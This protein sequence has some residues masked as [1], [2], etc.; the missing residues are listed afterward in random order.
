MVYRLIGFKDKKHPHWELIKLNVSLVSSVEVQND[1]TLVLH[2]CFVWKQL[3]VTTF[4]ST[5]NIVCFF[6]F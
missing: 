5:Q 4:I 1:L 6:N 3:D 2:K